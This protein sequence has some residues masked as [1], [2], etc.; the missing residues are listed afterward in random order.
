[1]TAAFIT[2]GARGI[3]E[4]TATLFAR[5]GI[6]VCVF[7]SDR[8]AG[9]SLAK[10]YPNDILFYCGDV[11]D[12]ASQR[13]ALFNCNAQLGPLSIVFANAGI[14]QSNTIETVSY[15]DLALLI[16]VNLKGMVT[17]I[18]E[19]VPFLVANGG[20]SIVVMSSDQAFIGKRNNF[21]YG[22]TKG[23]VAQMTRSLALDLA[24][25]KIRVNAV[26]PA[27]VRTDLSDRAV[28]AYAEKRFDG[29]CE[30]AWTAEAR[31]YPLQRVGE[32]ADVASLVYFLVSPKASFITGALYPIDGGL[33][34]G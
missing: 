25:N 19:S 7:D 10:T 5:S 17:T 13:E 34:A 22:L 6:K 16:D 2:G 21:A 30:K 1:M 20:G 23:A 12:P 14:H 27:T 9:E 3:G 33:T 32:S 15:E 4:A 26:C 24:P 29:D 11:R 18:K 31:R 28:R 8:E